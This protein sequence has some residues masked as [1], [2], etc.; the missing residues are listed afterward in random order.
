MVWSEVQ[1]TWAIVAGLVFIILGTMIFFVGKTLME[2]NATELYICKFWKINVWL[3]SFV[4]VSV[5]YNLMF[6]LVAP[7]PIPFSN[8]LAIFDIFWLGYVVGMGYL[9][10]S[11]I[12]KE[13]VITQV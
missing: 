3:V 5:L 11:L 10:Y 7:Y 13:K 2:N 8:T 6:G 1:R 12:K 9:T 4:P